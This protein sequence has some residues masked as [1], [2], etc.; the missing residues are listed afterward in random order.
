MNI[1]NVKGL[2]LQFD[3][4]NST[5]DDVIKVIDVVNS[6]LLDANINSQPQFIIDKLE[7]VVLTHEE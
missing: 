3:S 2:V 6:I 1:V 4:T 7:V 5:E